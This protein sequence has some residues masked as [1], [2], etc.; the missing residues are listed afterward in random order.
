MNYDKLFWRDFFDNVTLQSML[1][2]L[3]HL[4]SPERL[5][6]MLTDRVL[7][8]AATS[9]QKIA[10]TFDDGPQ[11]TYTPQLLDLLDRCGVRATFFLIGE[12][13]RENLDLAQEVARRGHEIG[14]HTFSH[15]FLVRLEDDE[16]RNEIERTDAL[17]RD[18][19]GAD[20]R[21]FR[22]PMG[23]F[24]KRV[25]DVIEQMGYQTVV[26]DVYPRDPH[27]PGKNRI[28]ERVL[29]RVMNGS[30]IILHDGGNSSHVDRSQTIS[31]VSELI[32]QLHER[33]FE[34]VRLSELSAAP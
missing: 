23:L 22:P 18:L 5:G 11:P 17:L 13:I 30:I 28:V 1:S 26:G 19:D 25:L 12:H 33:G 6:P 4:I 9:D 29:N 2:D 8:R 7:W 32:P 10:I 34:F 3:S 24:S 21:F 27:L 16:I 15:P 14:N 20:P 31:A